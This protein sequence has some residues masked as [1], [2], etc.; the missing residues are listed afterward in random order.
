MEDRKVAYK[1]Y[2][3][4]SITSEEL[5]SIRRRSNLKVYGYFKL[6]MYQISKLHYRIITNHID[7]S[8]L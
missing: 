1:D 5:V 2:H 7:A 3:W 6:K 8:I 4:N